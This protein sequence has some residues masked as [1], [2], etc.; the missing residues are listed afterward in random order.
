MLDL[1]AVSSIQGTGMPLYLH[2]VSRILRELRVLQQKN[3]TPFD[4]SAFKSA[5]KRAGLTEAQS[6][7]LQQRLETLESF[8]A[9]RQTTNRLGA[10]VRNDRSRPDSGNSWKP[11][12]SL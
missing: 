11:V 3:D 2:I 8:M 6:V 7:P 1:M 5:I 10:E 4:Y 12:V 9:L